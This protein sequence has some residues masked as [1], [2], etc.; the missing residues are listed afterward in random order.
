MERAEHIKKLISVN[1]LPAFPEIPNDNFDDLN[2][3]RDD[4]A[5]VE[6]AASD[7]QFKSSNS[8]SLDPTELK[9]LAITSKINNLSLVPFLK[10]DLKERFSF[11][12]PFS[13]K[14]GKLALSSKQKSRLKAWMRPDEFCSN[15][16]LIDK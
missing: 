2:I 16:V 3:S 6:P 5:F 7:E 1:N 15:P 13:D 4:E 14:D 11:S 8:N 12:I 10:T 9:I